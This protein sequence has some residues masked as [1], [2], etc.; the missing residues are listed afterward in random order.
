VIARCKEIVGF[1]A[2]VLGLVEECELVAARKGLGRNTVRSR[3][4]QEFL[5]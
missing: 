5:V 3:M 4:R 2:F 1:L